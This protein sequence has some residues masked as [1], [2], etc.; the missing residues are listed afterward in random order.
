MPDSFQPDYRYIDLDPDLLLTP[1]KVDTN[2]HVI[3]GAPSCGK[4]TLIDLL[5]AGGYCTLPEIAHQYI[6]D[7]LAHGLTLEEIFAERVTLQRVL[8]DLQTKAEEELS[9]DQVVFLD[10]AL[11]DSL[12]FNRFT[13][14][15]PNQLLK[16]CFC[17]RYASVFLLDPLPYHS[18][19]VRDF[20]ASNVAFLDEWLDRDYC[21]LGYDVIRVPVLPPQDRVD[22]I[23]NRLPDRT[24]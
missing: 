11:P 7:N 10:R 15:D 13:G 4:T 2:W 8:I 20:D 23:L 17:Y 24:P 14:L 3:T 18:N 6:T 22:Y 9:P 21:A 19:G 1:F 16:N 5:A 12:T